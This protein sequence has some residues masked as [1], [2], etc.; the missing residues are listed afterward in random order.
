MEEKLILRKILK[1]KGGS[2]RGEVIL[3]KNSRRSRVPPLYIQIF[4][5][6]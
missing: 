2:R 1:S 6:G 5:K 4:L 3:R